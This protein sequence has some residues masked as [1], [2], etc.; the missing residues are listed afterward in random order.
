MKGEAVNDPVSFIDED[1][2][3][4]S[5][6]IAWRKELS[7]LQTQVYK[8][9]SADNPAVTRAMQWLGP[10]LQAAGISKAN[11]DD[12]NEFVGQIQDQLVQFSKDNNKPPGIKDVQQM[13]ARLLQAHGADGLFLSAPKLY[14]A[15]VPED[16][17]KI[18]QSDPKWAANKIIPTPEMIQRVY[19]NKLYQDLYGGSKKQPQQSAPGQQANAGPQPPIS[20]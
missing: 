14:A 7:N 13:G 11:K 17:A 12:Y 8:N 15:P 9:P 1:V 19:V 6:P 4:K 10:N 3:G 5:M 20:Q 16:E 2:I 18:I